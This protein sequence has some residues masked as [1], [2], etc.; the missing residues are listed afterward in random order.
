MKDMRFLVDVSA[1]IWKGLLGNKD[2]DTGFEVK[3]EGK[4]VWVNGWEHGYNRAVQYI[5]GV[6]DRFR[7]QP[8]QLILV[9]EGKFS[10]SLRLAIDSDYKG[11]R[12]G[13]RPA[14]S[15]DEFAKARDAFVNALLSVG[16]QSVT[17]NQVEADD[18]IAYLSQR[19][20]G[21][22]VILSVDKDM[23]ALVR[24]NVHVWL[25]G[26]INPKKFGDI[27]P[28]NI[29]VYKALVGDTSDNIKG[30]PGFG[31]KAFEGLLEVFGDAGLTL[32]GQLIEK[33]EIHRLREDVQEFPKLQIVIDRH[34]SVTKS[35]KC[36]KFYP[37][38]VN[39]LRNPLMWQ[40]GMVKLVSE[41]DDL[42]LKRY[43]GHV[44]GVTRTNLPT[45]LDDINRHLA[46]SP[47]VA[48]DIET[49]T[50]DESSEWLQSQASDR[51][52]KSVDVFGSRLTGLGLTMGANNNYT[53]Y[54]SVDHKD[55]ANLTSEQVRDLVGGIQCQ[56]VIQNLN[57]ELTVLRQEWGDAWMDNGQHG[58]LT[59][60][61]DTKFMLSYVD[62][63]E[64]LGLKQASE[65]LL[66]YKQITYEEVTGGRKMNQLTLAEVLQYGADDTRCT[67]AIYNHCKIIMEMENTWHVYREVEI[68]AAYL[69]ALG[70]L[71]GVDIDQEE[72]LRQQSA[73]DILYDESWS[74]L[75]EFLTARGWNGC[76]YQP[77]RGIEDF[78]RAFELITGQ[79]YSTRVK[80]VDRVAQYVRDCGFEN[81]AVYLEAGDWSTI[82]ALARAKFNG[83][84]N[85]NID[86]PKQLSALLYDTMRLPIR[87]RNKATDKMREEGL[88]EGTPKTNA[89]ALKYASAFDVKADPARE[90]VLKA[91]LSMKLVKTRRKLFYGP[92]AFFPHW[93]D[94]K[95]H[96]SINQSATNTRRASGSNPNLQQLP[97]SRGKFRR[98]FVPHRPDAVIVSLDFAAQE[99]R[100]IADYSRDQNMLDCFIGDNLRDMHSLT[101]LKI[102][103]RE[104]PEITYEEFVEMVKDDSHPEAKWA[105]DLR[106]KGKTTNFASEYGAKAKKM[107]ETLMVSEDEAQTY[108]EAKWGTFWQ[109]EA[110]KEEVIREANR[111]GLSYTKMGAVRHL[112][113][114]ITTNNSYERGKA[115]RQSVNFR[116]QGSS[117][118]MTKLAM[119][120]M[121]RS[122]VMFRYDAR[123]FAPIHDEVVFSVAIKD[124]VPF[125]QEV[126]ACMVGK[127]ADMFVPIRSSI[128]LGK[129]FGDQIECGEEPTEAAL[130][131]GLEKTGY[132][133]AIDNTTVQR[134]ACELA[135]LEPDEEQ[136]EDRVVG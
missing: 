135:E 136:Q 94:G 86:S 129:S 37:D 87:L 71:H 88:R 103:Q 121:W 13:S 12:S 93:K 134:L 75:S 34:E 39:T 115:E 91:L 35:W 131:A 69:T 67:V 36:A 118:E 80:K 123:F 97:K 47:V 22:K 92:Y 106:G 114:G 90:A 9:V 83:A 63:N 61:E 29:T 31:D 105:K 28:H 1:I 58:F 18:I 85:F 122:G 119:G 56:K 126:H 100:V 4:S 120:R 102:A 124:L 133:V 107:A 45:L 27:S 60:V 5:V 82:D 32:L 49:S 44:I 130:L 128:S 101:A 15:Y 40:A 78:S 64:F 111:T 57:F 99:L 33:G 16:A 117:A 104:R 77:V 73:D 19:L 127:Y 66:K 95:V 6:L 116:I 55:E 8:H 108:L 70:F 48:L 41:V 42:R 2:H 74:Q 30:A 53:Y 14:E 51:A 81:L 79:P 89:L 7:A 65:R 21:Q 125:V 98:V 50:P 11:N 96:A 20:A 24:P 112:R 43:A 23:L 84:P 109:A 46:A 54:F 72:L 52:K 68:D 59:N 3:H 62:E 26:E 17:Q 25:D 113:A 110:W 10:K 38:Q 132:C 76:V